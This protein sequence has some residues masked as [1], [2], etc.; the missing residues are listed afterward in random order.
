MSGM[1]KLPQ[2]LSLMTQGLV[3]CYSA[4]L[5][6]LDLVDHYAA[7]LLL[8]VIVP[9]LLLVQRRAGEQIILIRSLACKI[10]FIKLY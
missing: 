8:G 4:H 7:Q 9:Q 3:T 2:L 5:L 6:L 1:G 10:C